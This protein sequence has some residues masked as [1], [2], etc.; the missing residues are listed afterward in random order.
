MP[1][2]RRCLRTTHMRFFIGCSSF[3]GGG[4]ALTSIALPSGRAATA[5]GVSKKRIFFEIPKR[6]QTKAPT[7]HRSVLA[8]AFAISLMGHRIQSFLCG[9]LKST[10]CIWGV[11]VRARW[12]TVNCAFLGKCMEI[13][14]WALGVVGCVRCSGC[15]R[16]RTTPC[17][18]ERKRRTEAFESNSEAQAVGPE[19]SGLRT[20]MAAITRTPS[21]QSPTSGANRIGLGG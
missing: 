7:S 18:A 11:L 2:I 5:L 10:A 3:Q 16:L 19:S 4:E 13:G 14:L 15:R 6:P 1:S 8:R 17:Q 20:T 12:F 21:A 9:G